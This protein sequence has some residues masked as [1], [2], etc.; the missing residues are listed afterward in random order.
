M[1]TY[2]HSFTTLNELKWNSIVILLWRFTIAMYISPD[3]LAEWHKILNFMT[4]YDCHRC[5]IYQIDKCS[6]FYYV[7]NVR[8]GGSIWTD[9]NGQF[10]FCTLSHWF[11]SSYENENNKNLAQKKLH[12]TTI[13]LWQI[14]CGLN[15]LN[16]KTLV[17]CKL[18]FVFVST[19]KSS[20]KKN[21]RIASTKWTIL[22]DTFWLEH[23]YVCVC[24]GGH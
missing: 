21:R 17:H 3:A 8:T 7:K 2:S 6:F 13:P 20:S 15:A 12:L 23:I 22:A 18:T 9:S 10:L 19:W 4:R 5:S 24:G 1:I 16:H 11:D 14:L